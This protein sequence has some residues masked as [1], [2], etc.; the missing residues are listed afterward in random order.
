MALVISIVRIIN[1]MSG[2]NRVIAPASVVVVL[3]SVVV[4]GISE[5]N[6]DK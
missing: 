2:R 3:E 6:D 5:E 4:L 1:K